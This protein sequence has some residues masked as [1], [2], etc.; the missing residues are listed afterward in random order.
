MA[1]WSNNVSSKMIAKVDRIDGE[2]FKPKYLLIQEKLSASEPMWKYIENIIHPGEFPRRYS[3]KGWTVIRAQN[4]R[5]MSM[6]I[7]DNEMFLDSA[8]V[9]KLVRN[10][11]TNEDILI[12]R[13]GA[14]FGQTS[15]Y[16]NERK[17]AI[18]TSHSLIIKTNK[19][20]HPAYLAL[21]L[22][23]YY[24]RM[25]INQCM[26][27]SS[28]PEI[29]PKFLKKIPVPRYSEVIENL[30]VNNVLKAYELRKNA[31][32]LYTQAQNILENGLGLDHLVLDNPKSY[33][34]SFSELVTTGRGDAEYFNPSTKEI[35]RRIT[36]LTHLKLKDCFLVANG[37][38]WNSWRFLSE[39]LG[40]PVV[41]IRNIRP[42]QIDNNSL[43]TLDKKY[44]N[45]LQVQK[46]QKGDIVVGMD[47]IKYF[48]SSIITENCFVNQRVAHLS[49]KP[50]N[51]ISPIYA[52]FIMNS[53]V[54]QN[55]LLRDMTVANTVGHITNRNI[56]E[57]VI[58]FP[59]KEFHD[60][61]TDLVSRSFNAKNESELLLQLAK[62]KVEDL[63]EGVIEQ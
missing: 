21:Y 53:K 24:G 11:V 30:I 1:V 36:S 3:N 39:G 15:L 20:I 22:N 42:G 40:E 31:K 28:Q 61:I 18:V 37:Y 55:Q 10:I 48:Y 29:A 46:A 57:L 25:L 27:G 8:E 17:N 13:T 50:G 6:E 16:T 35:V 63:I 54:G 19:S 59:S 7:D 51:F 45:Q 2:Y 43:T 49:P 4:V 41:R 33:E 47:G 34:T 14:N 5:P 38:P 62:K 23:T 44:V 52:S 32:S 60:T 56:R 9:S 26:Y 12:T 58:P